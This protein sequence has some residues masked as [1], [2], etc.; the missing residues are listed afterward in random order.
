MAKFHFRLATLLRLRETVRDERRVQ[1]AEAERAD[2]RLQA[3]STELSGQQRQL[4]DERRAAAGPGEVD[5][6]RLVE[7][8]QYAVAL[9]AQEAKLLEQRQALAVEI[10]RRRRTLLEADRDV[11]TIDKLRQSQWRAHRQ[12][13]ERQEGKQLEEAALR[14]ASALSRTSTA[15]ETQW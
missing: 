1:L 3:R 8:H 13:E 6:P 5:L 2:A 14:R 4:Q 15:G 7:A 11:Q 10:D 12:E 9:R